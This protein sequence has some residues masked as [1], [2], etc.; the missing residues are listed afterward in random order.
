MLAAVVGLIHPGM[1]ASVPPPPPRAVLNPIFAADFPD[2]MVLRVANVSY[3]FGTTGAWMPAGE[4]FPILRSSDLVHWSYLGA[5]FNTP[6]DWI[7]DD[8]W[9][10]SVLHTRGLYYLYYGARTR[11]HQ[12]CLAVAVAPSPIGPYHDNGPIGCGDAAA[13]GYI[14]PAPFL[15]GNDAYLYYSVDGPQHSISV[16][17]L[18]PDLLGL[19]GDRVAL[20]GVSQPWESGAVDSTVE[21]PWVFQR[22]GLY[23]LTYSGNSW[24]TDYG[25]GYATATSPL[26]PF[27]KSDGNPLLGGQSGLA[28]P[29]GGSV[30]E[31]G[32]GDLWLAF[33][34]WT[35]QERDLNLVRLSVEGEKL[36]L[37]VIAH[38]A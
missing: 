3:A 19:A 16:Q 31:D 12:H 1:P 33:H 20:F 34:S 8:A 2:P 21:A 22:G 36:H 15:D 26:G 14:D 17:R 13:S 37:G 4:L 6:P 28:A 5:V 18:R 32:R 10:P 11:D 29:G 9:A 7:L 27:T 35:N 38:A 24:R 23:F 30:F 25:T